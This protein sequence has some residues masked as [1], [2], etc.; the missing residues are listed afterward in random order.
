MD[1][2]MNDTMEPTV[3]AVSAWQLE[4]ARF[5]AFPV[6]SPLFMKQHWWQD[7]AGQPE[8]FR[9]TKTKQS[10]EEHGS[11]QGVT[12]SLTLD[13]NRVMWS[14]KPS[15]ELGELPDEL[16][17]LGPF[18]EKLA[19]FVELLTLWLAKSCPPIRRLALGGKLLQ[20]AATQQDAFRVLSCYLPGVNF[21]PNLPNDFILQTNRRRQ[22]AVVEGLPLKAVDAS[23]LPMVKVEGCL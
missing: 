3:P 18:R 8:D 15:A 11:F 5:I 9:S 12:L 10:V 2:S 13:R 17:I 7:L 20:V 16:P 6:D 19:W 4:S 14:V 23:P 22:S 1:N 21:E